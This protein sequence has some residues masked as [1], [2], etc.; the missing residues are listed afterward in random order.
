MTSIA[1]LRSSFWHRLQPVLISSKPAQLAGA[2]EKLEARSKSKQSNIARL[3]DRQTEPPLVPRANSGQA[4]RNDLAALGNKALKQPDIAVGDSV[5]LLGAEFANLLAP[6]KLAAAWTAAWTAGRTRSAGTGARTGV[7]A[8]G[9]RSGCVLFSRMRAAGFV[10]H[11]I[12]LSKYVVP[13]SL[14]TRVGI[15]GHSTS[16]R[17][18]E[19]KCG[20]CDALCDAYP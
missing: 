4:A 6:E 17:R 2:P 18:V 10:S 7:P 13:S 5:D 11:D 8:A 9:T 20:D 15:S 12:S 19:A 14:Q 16:Y 1:I 3:L